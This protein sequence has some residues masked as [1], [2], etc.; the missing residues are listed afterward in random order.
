MSSRKSPSSRIPVAV[1]GAVQ[2]NQVAAYAGELYNETGIHVEH[3]G[4]LRNFCFS[5]LPRTSLRAFSIER[6]HWTV[7]RSGS[8]GLSQMALRMACEIHQTAY[9]IK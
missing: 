4:D 3:A 9:E 1:N 5:P 6:A 8:C 2:G 7:E